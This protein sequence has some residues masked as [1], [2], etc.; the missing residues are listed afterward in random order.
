M[1]LQLNIGM[2]ARFARAAQAFSLS[3]CSRIGALQCPIV[4]NFP[5]QRRNL[6][7]APG[8]ATP[9]QLVRLAQTERSAGAQTRT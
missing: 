7:V 1:T 5:M 3:F 6:P 8:R 4:A 2:C 9:E